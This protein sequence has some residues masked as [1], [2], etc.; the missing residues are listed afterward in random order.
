MTRPAH[1]DKTVDRLRQAGAGISLLASILIFA[2]CGVPQD[3]AR[4][5][6]SDAGPSIPQQVEQ[7]A[8]TSSMVARL[9]PSA[10]VMPPLAESPAGPSACTTVPA[11]P[12]LLLDGSMPGTPRVDRDPVTGSITQAL[13]GEPGSTSAVVQDLTGSAGGSVESS[14]VGNSPQ[15]LILTDHIEIAIR[16]TGD[17]DTG[18][19]GLQTRGGGDDCVRNYGIGPGITLVQT[20][21]YARQW[22]TA[23]GQ[24]IPETK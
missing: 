1:G 22:A 21:E 19:I 7:P 17:D 10:S 2:A 11:A 9:A 5:R 3:E 12:P 4:S 16:P 23:V 20:R 24:P 6:S 13:W 18:T 15:N 14:F 8:A